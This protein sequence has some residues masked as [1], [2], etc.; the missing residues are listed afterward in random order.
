MVDL[1]IQIEKLTKASD[2]AP[3]VRPGDRKYLCPTS[4][5]QRAYFFIAI[6]VPPQKCGEIAQLMA[7][8]L[9]FTAFS[10]G[11]NEGKNISIDITSDVSSVVSSGEE[12]EKKKKIGGKKVSVG[13][14]HSLRATGE[15]GSAVE[16]E[17]EEE[18][19][20]ENTTPADSVAS[21]FFLF[22]LL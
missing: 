6:D 5:N 10:K 8:S 13:S 3:L 21:M 1:I 22:L 16:E 11:S 2:P 14:F 19:V 18:E 20:K 15:L 7:S 4:P 17:E 9:D 12:V